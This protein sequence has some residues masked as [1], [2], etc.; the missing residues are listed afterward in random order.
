MP[1][2]KL[3]TV[4]FRPDTLAGSKVPNVTGKGFAVPEVI[5]NLYSQTK[6][7]ITVDTDNLQIVWNNE[8]EYSVLT[9]QIVGFLEN[10]K[11][12]SYDVKVKLIQ[13]NIILQVCWIP[14]TMYNK[15]WFQL[16]YLRNKV[17]CKGF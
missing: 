11:L 4:Q 15:G 3:L 1:L 6:T 9:Y 14:Q 13:E 2:M 12:V 17:C 8:L 16:L 5:I 7:W 10:V